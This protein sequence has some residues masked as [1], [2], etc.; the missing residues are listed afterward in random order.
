MAK[1]WM[2]SAAEEQEHPRETLEVTSASEDWAPGI[3]G[4]DAEEVD[5]Q[6]HDW[7]ETLLQPEQTMPAEEEEVEYGTPAHYRRLEGRLDDMEGDLAQAV[8]LIGLLVQCEGSTR[9][10]SQARG[11]GGAHRRAQPPPALP[12]PGPQTPVQAQPGPQQPVPLP[13]TQVPQPQQ[14]PPPSLALTPQPLPQQ[15]PVQLAPAPQPLLPPVQPVPALL[16]VPPLPPPV[17]PVPAPQ[18]LP[19]LPVP[20]PLPQPPA[21]QLGPPRRP[22][23]P[24]RQAPGGPARPA[25]RPQQIPGRVPAPLRP[26]LQQPPQFGPPPLA[27]GRQGGA[28]LPMGWIKLEAT[29]DGDT[30]KLGFF[31]VQA[32]QVF[33]RWGY[34]FLDE[35]SRVTHLASRLEGRA[36][37][38]YV[39]LYY[40]GAPELNTLQ[41]FIAT[42]RAK[43]E[44]PLEE[45]RTR[46]ELQ[47]LRQGSQPVREYAA[48]FRQLAAKCPHCEEGT[49]IVMFRNGMNPRL[50]NPALM[51]DDPP[52]L[53]GWIQLACEVENR[54]QV[55]RLVEQQQAMGYRRPP[56]VARGAHGVPPVR[57][58]RETRWRQDLCLQCGNSGHFA[59]ECPF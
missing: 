3:S 47:T 17:L 8:Y 23:R 41:D 43:Y 24:G 50:L 14:P 36:A 57:G 25:H 59:A 52:T 22:A 39:T 30:H 35:E 42:L 16:P 31:V 56:P 53:M 29:F 15:L 6:Q 33:N 26:Q 54:T 37:E 1:G 40:S 44:D 49:K 46:T 55:V 45:E 11:A 5:R 12:A 20:G 34:L 38:W 10:V 19:Q 4:D 2:A 48:K 32:L 27:Q 28:E 9:P 18:P 51:Q 7:E 21:G 13:A 58:A